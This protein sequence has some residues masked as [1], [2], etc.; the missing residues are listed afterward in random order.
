MAVGRSYGLR[1][2]ITPKHE[3]VPTWILSVSV[4]QRWFAFRREG[5]KHLARN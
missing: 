1:T 3:A 4:S 2:E 5:G